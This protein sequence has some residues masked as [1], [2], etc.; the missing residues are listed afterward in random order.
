MPPGAPRKKTL[1]QMPQKGTRQCSQITLPGPCRQAVV[2]WTSSGQQNTVKGSLPQTKTLTHSVCPSPKLC[3]LREITLRRSLRGVLVAK[4]IERK[5]SIEACAIPP[6]IRKERLSGSVDLYIGFRI[7][8]CHVPIS[9]A[10]WMTMT[11]SLVHSSPGLRM[12]VH[13]RAA[14]THLGLYSGAIGETRHKREGT[15]ANGR[16][17]QRRVFL[18]A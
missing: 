9:R 4:A 14:E 11:A 8:R 12:H 16:T 1:A 6:P 7:L 5:R 2:R 15:P 18:L 3:E 17:D 13:L 10:I